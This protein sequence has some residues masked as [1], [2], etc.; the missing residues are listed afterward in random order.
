MGWQIISGI[1]A[2]AGLALGIWNRVEQWREFRRRTAVGL[3]VFTATLDNRVDGG[4]QTLKLSILNPGN[5]NFAMT[6]VRVIAPRDCKIAPRVEV[7]GADPGL[8][9]MDVDWHVYSK[10]Q[11]SPHQVAS[12]TLF[13][14][15]VAEG[16]RPKLTISG[17]I[18]TSGRPT[19]EEPVKVSLPGEKSEVHV[20][21]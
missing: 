19:F 17:Y 15:R 4:W 2:L 6:R 8:R 11:P 1:V 10:S 5:L 3:P 18:V 21:S 14:C 9:S 12:S 7:V 13:R 20:P 16:S